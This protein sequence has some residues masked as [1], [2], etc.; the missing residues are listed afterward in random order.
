MCNVVCSPREDVT[1]PL[2]MD[3]TKEKEFSDEESCRRTCA[4]LTAVRYRG[5]LATTPMWWALY[6]TGVLQSNE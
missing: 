1:I 2:E 5:L 4:F 3:Y 6:S